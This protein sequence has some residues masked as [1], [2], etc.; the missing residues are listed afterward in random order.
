MKTYSIRGLLLFVLAVA[1]ILAISTRNVD[2]EF[3][4]NQPDVFREGWTIALYEGD[5]YLDRARRI[6]CVF[7]RYSGDGGSFVA[8]MRFIDWLR[9]K[10][11]YDYS[12]EGPELL[13]W[14]T[15]RY[16]KLDSL[17]IE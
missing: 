5:R 2:V 16:R 13:F 8:R 15:V 10:N 17:A 11:G 9:I 3:T 6:E 1:V 12:L 7:V 14:P 4:G